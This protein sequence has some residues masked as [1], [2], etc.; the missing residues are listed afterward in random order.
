MRYG[1]VIKIHEP[2]EPTGTDR[3]KG[4]F[5]EMTTLINSIR[6]IHG[7]ED[8]LLPP[9]QEDLM[10][11]AKYGP[12]VFVLCG[13][14][15]GA[16]KAI[17]VESTRIEAIDLPQ[18]EINEVT[19][20][21]SLMKAEL[22]SGP[23]RTY[24]ARNKKYRDELRWLWDAVVKPVLEHIHPEFKESDVWNDKPHLHWIGVGIFSGIP[25][26]A[27]G[28]HSPG[29]CSNTISHAISS[30]ALSVRA[31]QY[32]MK[33][34]AGIDPFN[35]LL[36]A[37]M[38]ETPGA[39]PLPSVKEELSAVSSVVGRYLPI[40]TLQQPTPDEVLE[41]L[42]R[43]NLI[44]F[45]CHGISD[46]GDPFNSRLLLNHPNAK[47]YYSTRNDTPGKVSV[48]DLL[49]HRNPKADLAYL[50]ACSTA[51]IK[52]ASLADE[53]VHI[54]SAFQLAG[55][56]HVVASLWKQKDGVCLDIAT[57]FYSELFRLRKESQ[58]RPA[59]GDDW[60]VA[61][62]LHNAV[63]QVRENKPGMVLQWASFVHIGG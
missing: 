54:A 19:G 6:A 17:I 43:H 33:A 46:S 59:P 62:A 2:D 49:S 36:V 15:V 14:V 18:L 50:S 53:S 20:R 32:A 61:I 28:E 47:T 38:G 57:K 21:L 12:I 55:F 63:S 52:V 40:V 27:A 7:L 45:A 37:A 3:R 23:L 44:H 42:P 16:G 10:T 11:M 13:H 51:D 26:H 5:K 29:S 8:F 31:L 1:K 9:R 25:F 39:A 48:R 60:P 41:E 56:R 4:L 30:H 58:A 22:P 24:A 35:R 34:R